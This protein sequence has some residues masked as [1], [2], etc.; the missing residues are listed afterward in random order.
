MYCQFHRVVVDCIVMFN[1]MFEALQYYLPRLISFLS[2]EVVLKKCDG[3]ICK[4]AERRRSPNPSD[5]RVEITRVQFVT[6]Y[7]C[8]IL[9]TG[10]TARLS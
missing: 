7:K 1:I 4:P 5:G 2:A 8:R 9:Q 3:T 6:A 10:V